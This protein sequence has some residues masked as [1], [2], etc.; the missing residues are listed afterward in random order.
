M[1]IE[2]ADTDQN[3]RTAREWEKTVNDAAVRAAEKHIP[4]NGAFELTARCN[5]RCKMCYV[6]LDGD[7]IC[8]IGKELTAQEWISLAEEALKAGMLNLLLTGGEPL[9]R[10]DFPEIYSALS[11]MGFVITLFTNGTLI[12]PEL[13]K[14]L[15]KYPPT[16]TS[17]TLY[18]AN[19]HTYEKICGSADAFANALSGLEKLSQ[20]PTELEVSATLIRDNSNELDEIR[21]IAHRFTK[22]F[23]VNTMILKPVRGAK[24]DVDGCRL[25]PAQAAKVAMTC[26]ALNNVREGT[27]EDIAGKM[28]PL[29]PDR[30]GYDIYP[31]ILPCRAAKSDFYITWDG[32]MLPCAS[33]A[34][35]FALPV[36]DGFLTAWNRLPA[37]F[38]KISKPSECVKCEFNGNGCPNCPAFLQSETGCYDKIADYLCSYMREM[39]RNNLPDI[40]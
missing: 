17:V 22:Q 19:P 24:A 16:A 27:E 36:Q 29:S 35:P 12:S 28:L 14:L 33:F 30:K 23:S 9:L 5:L 31:E 6:R 10:P 7:Q 18:G 13:L 21:A 32:K 15:K 25:T 20:V 40:E 11:Q 2:R 3:N 37:L 8:S 4:L 34:S 39:M 26:K 1:N 38:E